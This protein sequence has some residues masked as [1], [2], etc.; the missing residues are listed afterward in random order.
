MINVYIF[1]FREE[2]GLSN[3]NVNLGGVTGEQGS[4]ISM[5]VHCCR[6]SKLREH[7]IATEARLF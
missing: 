7:N 6:C 4:F 5:N 3:V 1:M 2:S